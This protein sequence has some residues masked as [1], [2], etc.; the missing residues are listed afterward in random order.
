MESRFLAPDVERLIAFQDQISSIA[1]KLEQVDPMDITGDQEKIKRFK[2]FRIKWLH[3]VEEVEIGILK[4][5]VTRLNALDAEFEAGINA[6]KS[7]LQEA[8]DIVAIL[9]LIERTLL[10]IGQIV[11]LAI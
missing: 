3:V 10:V 9:S 7:A 8:N 2:A 5:I 11:T 4:I 1:E 6:L